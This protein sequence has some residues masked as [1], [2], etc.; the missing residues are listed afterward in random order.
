VTDTGLKRRR[1]ATLARKHQ[2][3]GLTANRG[4]YET[5]KL[6]G[7]LLDRLESRRKG[8]DM[9]SRAVAL[10]KISSANQ[11]KNKNAVAQLGKAVAGAAVRTTAAAG[12]VLSGGD[13]EDEMDDDVAAAAEEGEWDTDATYDLIEQT[14]GLLILADKQGLDLFGESGIAAA[15]AASNA[16]K[17]KAK[18]R[19]GRFPS[20]SGIGHKH[21]DEVTILLKR[22]AT[23]VH[24]L[25]TTDCI[26]TIQRFRL[27]KPPYALQTMVLDVA[28][29]LYHKGDL[30]IKV[31]MMNAVIDSLY[32]MGEP[33]HEKICQWLEGRMGELLRRL[34]TER[35]P[36][37]DDDASGVNFNGE[38]V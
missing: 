14:R 2:A 4:Q 20:M 19:A 13:D 9:L 11:A 36:P 30:E 12:K 21:N 28:A 25:V 29:L 27:I 23:A 32:T 6:L 33:M 8:P 31:Q 18:N 37:E 38:L 22:L 16:A 26:Y 34:A 17:Q 35:S 3:A 7:H 24:S 1:R 15:Q 5:Q 10:A